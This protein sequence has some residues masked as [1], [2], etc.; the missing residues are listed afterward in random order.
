MDNGRWNLGSSPSKALAQT[1]LQ[2][3]VAG[4]PELVA[5]M[6]PPEIDVASSETYNT[7]PAG[8]G[9]CLSFARGRRRNRTS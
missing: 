8:R 6:H 3:R 7:G 4:L 1:A 5:D 9:R 2:F